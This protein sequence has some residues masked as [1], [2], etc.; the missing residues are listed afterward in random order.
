M[1]KTLKVSLLSLFVAVQL[2][3]TPLL[4]SSV[5]ALPVVKDAECTPVGAPD[6]SKF[7][8]NVGHPHKVVMA[9]YQWFETTPDSGVWELKLDVNPIGGKEGWVKT[10]PAWWGKGLLFW[11]KKPVELPQTI[12]EV[13][14]EEVDP[15]EPSNPPI[16][17]PQPT[18]APDDGTSGHRSSMGN[19]N[20]RCSNT[21]FDAVMEV[22]WDGRPAQDV[23]VVF[24]FDGQRVEVRS[25]ENGQARTQFPIKSGVLI[26][27]PEGYPTQSQ[28]I[29]A[30]T[31]DDVILD[32]DRGGQVLGATTLADTGSTNWLAMTGIYAGLA[33]LGGA[34][35][36]YR[37]ENKN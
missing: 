6:Q 18:P 3:L 8:R 21:M 28:V 37:K 4:A 29:E 32:P 9:T 20:L 36:A 24:Y 11:L 12:T 33:T 13:E 2:V 5:R 30:P 23:K 10:Y 26:G 31:C 7:E 25:N 27:E 14:C 19:D 35:Y 17:G 22:K 15:E 16:G 1:K 34:A